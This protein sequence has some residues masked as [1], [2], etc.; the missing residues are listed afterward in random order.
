[1]K[2][3]F[4][5]DGS[6]SAV[7]A[8]KALLSFPFKSAMEV[9]VV[10]VIQPVQ[11][12]LV[13]STA[14]KELLENKLN[15]AVEQAK[16]DLTAVENELR[17]KFAKVHGELLIGDAFA[18]L[19][20]FNERIGFDMIVTG[21]KG[22]SMNKIFNVGGLPVKLAHSVRTNLLTISEDANVKDLR[23]MM[24]AFDGSQASLKI[25]QRMRQFL[26]EGSDVNVDLTSVIGLVRIFREEIGGDL[27]T[28]IDDLKKE[29][30]QGQSE[31]AE[32]IRPFVRATSKHVIE[33]EH[34]TSQTLIEQA[35]KNKNGI[36]CLGAH[37]YSHFERAL[38][39]SVVEK[40]LHS[41]T[42]SIWI[43]Q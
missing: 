41:N 31:L 5:Y 26:Q 10:T 20:K 32:N 29:F 43:F 6:R 40:M 35:M 23:S 24:I 42:P 15:Q 21:K 4:A 2:V 3:L 39:G 22:H 27:A 33:S 14:H 8:K 17:N 28:Y 36:I 16:Q 37:G 9:W 19:V 13:M 25:G 1:M 30:D 18:E 12:L 34:D 38:L 7:N 11:S